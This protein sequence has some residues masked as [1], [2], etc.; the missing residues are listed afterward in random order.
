MDRMDPLEIQ[1]INITKHD[2]LCIFYEIY[3]GDNKPI[4]TTF[5]QFPHSS[6][7]I[8][9]KTVC[10]SCILWA[11]VSLWMLSFVHY[12]ITRAI[13]NAEIHSTT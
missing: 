6:V 8:S 1:N 9:V 7:I 5:V 12:V 4:A 2:D 10:L 11:C 13:L 3:F